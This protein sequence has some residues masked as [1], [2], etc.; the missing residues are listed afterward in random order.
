MEDPIIA[1]DTAMTKA[2]RRPSTQKYCVLAL[3]CRGKATA[4]GPTRFRVR[5]M[6][7]AVQR[8]RATSPS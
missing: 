4:G 8:I 1:D 2:E 7:A 5:G 6:E 3:T